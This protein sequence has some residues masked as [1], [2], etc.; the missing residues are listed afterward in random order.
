MDGTL[1]LRRASS[2]A[3]EQV[4]IVLSAWRRQRGRGGEGPGLL[5][6]KATRLEIRQF[7]CETTLL[8]IR[9]AR[10]ATLRRCGLLEGGKPSERSAPGWAPARA[11]AAIRGCCLSPPPHSSRPPPMAPSPPLPRIEVT[12]ATLTQRLPSGQD[13]R[14]SLVT[15]TKVDETPE[16]LLDQN[17]GFNA[18]AD[19]VN[20]KGACP[21]PLHLTPVGSSCM[22]TDLQAHGS[23]MW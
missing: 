6:S 5:A 17:A 18:N 11:R 7:Q 23:S 9:G 14:A 20:Y 15:V 8:P 13:R 21:P 1:V 22:L 19:W 2:T 10:N 4:P 12:D 3:W 16:Q